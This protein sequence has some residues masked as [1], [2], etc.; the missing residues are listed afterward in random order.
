MPSCLAHPTLLPHPPHSPT[1]P[2]TPLH[3]SCLTHVPLPQSFVQAVS[4]SVGVMEEY[5]E[6]SEKQLEPSQLK[7]VLKVLPSFLKVQY[8]PCSHLSSLQA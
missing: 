5:V 3:D 4:H 7:K 8:V 1:S 6:Q 2:T